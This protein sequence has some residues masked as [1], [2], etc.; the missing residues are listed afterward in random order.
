MSVELVGYT[1]S[2]R[3]GLP[4][5]G[6]TNI[7]P[8]TNIPTWAGILIGIAAGYFLK[9]TKSHPSLLLMGGL[10]L[11]GYIITKELHTQP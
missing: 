7:S 11:I 5:I 3:V 4:S 8:A 9:G 1:G 6:P 2:A 10:G